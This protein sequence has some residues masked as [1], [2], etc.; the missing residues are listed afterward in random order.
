MQDPEYCTLYYDGTQRLR[1]KGGLTLICPEFI[2]FAKLLVQRVEVNMCAQQ[3]RANGCNAYSI[4]L[5]NLMQDKGLKDSFSSSCDK[6]KPFLLTKRLQNDILSELIRRTLNCITNACITILN[7]T[8]KT[9]AS[10]M[11]IREQLKAML[12]NPGADNKRQSK[13]SKKKEGKDSA[14]TNLD[15]D[16]ADI[17]TAKKDWFSSANI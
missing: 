15:M 12:K 3:I 2:D 1:N 11:K 4:A 16:S 7:D 8:S 10:Q 17:D 14:I 5:T 13:S 6:L 9:K